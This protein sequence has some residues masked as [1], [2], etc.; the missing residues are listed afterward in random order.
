MTM[1]GSGEGSPEGEGLIQG[2][3]LILIIQGRNGKCLIYSSGRERAGERQKS[4]KIN[5]MDNGKLGSR[6]LEHDLT[7]L[8]WVPS[9]QRV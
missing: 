8:V 9:R 4:F 5:S 2:H 6:G 7:Y 3:W 1:P